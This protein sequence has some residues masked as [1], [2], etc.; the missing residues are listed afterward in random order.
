MRIVSLLS[1]ATE[2]LHHLGLT[3]DLVGISHECDYPPEVLDRPRVSRV[4]F[5]PAGMDS[6][7][8]DAAVRG[9][10][11]RYGSVYEVDAGMLGS[12]RPDL[13]LT[14][15]VCE[16][17]AVP[18]P[19]VREVAER[20]PR[21]PRILSLDA[22]TIEDIVSS[23]EIVG[24]AAG[25]AREGEQSAAALRRRIDAIASTVAGCPLPRV[26]LLEW[27][28]PPFVPGHWVPEMVSLA[29]GRCLAGVPGQRS[30]QVSWDDLQGLDPDI[31]LVEPCGYGLERAAAEAE[32]FQDRIRRVAPRAV[33]EG[34]IWAL[35]SARFSRSGPRVA[36]GVEALAAILHPEVFPESPSDNT[37]H[38]CA[39]T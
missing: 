11:E 32:R 8:I 19:S 27:L 2:I 26:L 20:L 36:E 12:L 14:Q 15:A 3:T 25:A 10:M 35:D 37:A 5:D 29:G 23:V 18:T 31:V 17:C 1:S 33:A 13:V 16:V 22:H 4:R 24:V 9:S 39:R 28:D 21:P 38:R 34:R 7:E 6:A 30:V